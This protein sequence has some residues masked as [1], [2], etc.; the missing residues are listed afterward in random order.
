MVAIGRIGEQD[1]EVLLSPV[2]RN[3]PGKADG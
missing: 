2:R 3:A 1:Q